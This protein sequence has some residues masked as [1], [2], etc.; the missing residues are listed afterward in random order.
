MGEFTCKAKAP[1]ESSLCKHDKP[2][3][4]RDLG[5]AFFFRTCVG[6]LVHTDAER[7]NGLIMEH[8]FSYQIQNSIVVGFKKAKRLQ[9]TTLNIL[10]NISR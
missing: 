3:M 10:V 8:H 4:K 6:V 2:R 7:R 9:I 1:S 5:S